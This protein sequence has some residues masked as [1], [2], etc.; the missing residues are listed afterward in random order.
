M[1]QKNE[2]ERR[3]RRGAEGAEGDEHNHSVAPN[4]GIADRGVRYP[5]ADV[6]NLSSRNQ[7]PG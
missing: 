7:M 5:K 1:H 4:V 6:E 3:E 2:R